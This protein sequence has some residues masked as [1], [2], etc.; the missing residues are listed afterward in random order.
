MSMRTHLLSGKKSII[1]QVATKM[2]G[3]WLLKNH[4]SFKSR[5][6][7]AWGL[8][9]SR[10]LYAIEVWGPAATESQ[11]K[12]MQTVQNTIL[13]FICNEKR[14]TRTRDLLRMSGM[15]SVRQL[16]VFRVLVTGLSA[17][18]RRRPEGMLEWE[19]IKNRRL[20]TTERSFRH[21]FGILL[22]K[23][24]TNLKEGDPSKMKHQLKI[25]VQQNIPM[26]QKWNCVDDD[27][28]EDEEAND[29]T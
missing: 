11:L 28:E 17:L 18:N 4:L 25:W 9:M 6:V 15:L 19:G 20:K 8:A 27:E 7:T 2:R 13:R 29:E 12:Q 1:N 22:S 16:V 24:P 21:M 3:L 5:K 23:L 26:E 10:I 14:G